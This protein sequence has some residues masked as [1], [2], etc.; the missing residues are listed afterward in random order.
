[1]KIIDPWGSELP[2]DY[3]KIM[4]D[5]GLEKFN[6]DLFPNPSRAMRRGVIFSGRDLVRISECI[7][8]KKPFYALTGIMPS[9]EQIHFGNKLVIE[10]L[11]Y[12]QDRGAVVYVLVADLECMAT[13]GISLVE[14]QRR[15]LNFHI[16]AY[17]ALGLDPLKTFFYFQSQNIDV[18]HL[19]FEFAQK[20]TLNEF[21]GIYGV[22]DPG[23]IMAAV[24]Q[25]GDI[26]FPQLK[27][28]MPGIIPEGVDQD[29]HIRL[30]RDIVSRFKKYNFVPP[31]ALYNKF[32]PSLDG[33]IKMSKSKPEYAISL[34]EDLSVVKKKIM[35]ALSGGRDTLEE[36]RRLGAVVERD[37]CFELLKQ[38]L[39][40]DDLELQRIYDEYSS[41]RMLSGE[42]KQ[43]TFKLMEDFMTDF[44]H[45]L[46]AARKS[47]DSLKFIKF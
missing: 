22:A 31:S 29:P 38:H 21:K 26:L 16:P 27:E 8:K 39:V 25:A 12:F 11:R 4:K 19:G 47:V 23:R 13:R 36:H 43:L 17:I 7:K 34:P 18:V 2:S 20:I 30:T 14:A 6:L 24:T 46:D 42:L 45:K 37:M 3:V 10:S 15:A 32:T 41:G 40:E 5:F 28:R 33:D 35:R 9:N 1:M 44:S